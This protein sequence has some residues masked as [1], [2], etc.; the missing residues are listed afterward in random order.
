MT[1]SKTKSIDLANDD[2]PNNL[3]NIESFPPGLQARM[4][5]RKPV[6]HECLTPGPPLHQCL[7]K[8]GVNVEKCALRTH[9]I[10][11]LQEADS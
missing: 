9:T 8:V 5:L 11:A 10:S 2:S 6:V 3:L 7:V 4:E 1:K